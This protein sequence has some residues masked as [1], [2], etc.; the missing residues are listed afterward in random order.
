M[1]LLTF[2]KEAKRQESNYKKI[3]GYL[4]KKG[5]ATNFEMERRFHG[6]WHARIDEM[7][8][9]GYIIVANRI[10]NDGLWNYIYKDE[11]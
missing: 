1:D 5:S 4:Q 6:R 3:L 9:D 10:N 11:R 2:H 8:K 7:R